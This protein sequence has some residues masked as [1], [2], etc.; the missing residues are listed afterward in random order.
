M[1]P[2]A[3]PS[4]PAWLALAILCGCAAAP[5][6]LR[7][8]PAGIP[9]DRLEIG[10]PIERS[11]GEQSELVVEA[12]GT[13]RYDRLSTR[14]YPD[15]PEVGLY[16]IV[17]AQGEIDR[18]KANLAAFGFGTLAPRRP[19]DDDHPGRAL[20]AIVQGGVSF[21][22][23][24]GK[25]LPLHA[26][27]EASLHPVVDR[28]VQHP[29]WAYRLSVPDTTVTEGHRAILTVALTA[30]GSGVIP[31]AGC[32]FRVQGLWPGEDRAPIAVEPIG[33]PAAAP[34]GGGKHD[35]AIPGTYRLVY[36]VR[37][38]PPGTKLLLVTCQATLRYGK[39][40]GN[41]ETAVT[42]TVPP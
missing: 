29:R 34:A 37:G 38:V 27:L 1:R 2:C 18:I 10:T 8:D 40:A 12:S 23:Y 4:P 5:P 14:E 20:F 22:R 25:R 24:D 21:E 19:E 39:V 15:L 35:L 16:E 13:V 26:R 42:L 9:F 32:D 41:L 17:L 6:R 7:Q 30:R 31:P 11:Y 28:V 33:T 36:D 3:G